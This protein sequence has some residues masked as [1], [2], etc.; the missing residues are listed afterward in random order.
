MRHRVHIVTYSNVMDIH[1]SKEVERN[2]V[3]PNILK[4]VRD[5]QNEFITEQVN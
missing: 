2:I 1:Y 5:W 3:F 4:Y